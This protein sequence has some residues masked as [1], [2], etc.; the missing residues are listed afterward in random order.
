LKHTPDWPWTLGP[1]QV[2]GLQVSITML[3]KEYILSI[4][5]L[6]CKF[7]WVSIGYFPSDRILMFPINIWQRRIF[8]VVSKSMREQHR[9]LWSK[10]S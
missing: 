1:S 8:Q 5:Y 4:L 10:Y 6:L 2:Q 9:L 3:S 7:S